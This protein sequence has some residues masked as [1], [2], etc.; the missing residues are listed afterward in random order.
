MLYEDAVSRLEERYPP[1]KRRGVDRVARIL[2]E[3]GFDQGTLPSVHITGTNGKFSTAVLVSRLLQRA[4]MQVG[5]F[6]SPHIHEV[7]ERIRIQGVPISKDRFVDAFQRVYPVAVRLEGEGH[8][9][10]TF[11]DL[12]TI[13]ALLAFVDG[14]VSVAVLEV[15]MGGENDATNVCD[16]AVS[17]IT[18]I[19]E[20]HFAELGD[21]R[22]T[23]WEKSGV[24]KRGAMVVS[25]VRQTELRNV[26]A[27]RSAQ[28]LARGIVQLGGDL[29]VR[30]TPT[31]G[32]QT[33]EVRS[34]V[35]RYDPV[36][37]S[38]RGHHQA[39][40]AALAVA[41]VECALSAPLTSEQLSSAFGDVSLPA[42]LEVV[43]ENP[44]VVIDGGHNADAARCVMTALRETF[45]GRRILLVVGMLRE[46]A[47]RDVA[48]EFLPS[49]RVYVTEILHP[50]TASVGD[51]TAAFL[52]LGMSAS[53]ITA[54][55]SVAEALE[56][57]VREA[58]NDHLVVVFGSFYGAAAARSA[59]GL[60]ES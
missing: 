31:P 20:D 32:G 47:L 27:A 2:G 23:A 16:S 17:V 42:R 50:R 60:T 21:L 9:M 41:A 22:Q 10:A 49:G 8:E 48:R 30:R 59:L 43:G 4:G 57:A 18:K 26:I 38:L 45:P 1:R 28:R 52:G 6:T 40:N 19:A 15:G 35:A 56:M 14:G 36:S 51:L 34:P 58:T 3:L 53:H 24:I 12:M 55:R 7:T 39:H 13:M 46:K 5:L 11:F 54:C 37:L 25:G 29:T 44:T 33:I